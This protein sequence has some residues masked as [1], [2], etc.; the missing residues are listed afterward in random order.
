[1]RGYHDLT[2]NTNSDL[3]ASYSR[4]HN[5]SALSMT[6]DLGGFYYAALRRRCHVALAAVAAIHLS[7]RS[8]AGRSCSG[9]GVEQPVSQQN[10]FGYYVSGDYQ[11]ARRWFAG[12]RYDR[13]R[14][15]R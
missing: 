9:A 1:M 7:I 8:S 2:E 12:A 3:G 15:C 10:A 5:A 11:F 14:S 4:G 13:S 6:V